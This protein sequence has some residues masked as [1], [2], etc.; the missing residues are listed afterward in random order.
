[1]S[2]E[3]PWPAAGLEERLRALG[4]ERYHHRHPFNLRMHEGLLSPQELRRWIL[5]RFHYQRH[6]PVKDALILARLGT[7]ELRRSWIR[8]IHDHDGAPDGDGRD[9]GIERWLRLGEAAGLD[10]ARLLSGEDVLPGVRLAVDGYV[11][12]CG[13]RPPLESVASSL[14]ELFAPDLMAT[15]IAAWERHYPWVE[16]EG[17]RYFRVRVGQGRRDSEEALGL[18]HRWA[19][20]RADQERVLAAFAF[21]CDLLWSLLDAVE[22]ARETSDVR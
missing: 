17:L 5:N 10:R 7:R 3:A 8:R 15:R 9:G 2:A 19:R 12:F 22:H 14:T 6:I 16:P 20:T 21:K 1:M 18:V 4:E 13:S 11:N